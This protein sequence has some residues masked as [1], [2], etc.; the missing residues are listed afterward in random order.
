MN[1]IKGIPVQ[2]P[3]FSKITF[4]LE[5]QIKQLAEN[6]HAIKRKLQKFISIVEI[7]NSPSKGESTTIVED[8]SNS[9]E[10]LTLINAQLAE[11]RISLI[12]LVEE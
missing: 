4:G 8:L 5:E 6:S 10:K 3:I 7:E 11:C 12:K 9:I 1:E 2:E